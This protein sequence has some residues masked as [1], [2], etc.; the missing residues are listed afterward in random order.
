[1]QPGFI[2]NKSLT[3]KEKTVL[4]AVLKNKKDLKILLRHSWYRIPSSY[5]PKRKADYIAFYQ[6]S[7]FG[8]DGKCIRYFA[9]IKNISILKRKYLLPREQSHDRADKNYHKLTLCRIQKLKKPITNKNRMRVSFGF[10]TLKK[11][12]KAREVIDLFDIPP[13]ES[14]LSK[15]LNKNEIAASRQHIIRLPNLKKHILDFAVFCKE[16][17]LNI[18]CDLEKW[19]LIRAQRIKDEKRDKAL[20]KLGW[21]ILRLKG[22]EI[23]ND[24]E[25]C[26]KNIK[27]K[28]KLLGGVTN[29]LS[30][31]RVLRSP[32]A[33]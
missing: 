30:T 22:Y 21:E 31:Y 25:G 20:K 2:K 24:I 16:G 15:A 5:I 29:H 17:A 3:L 11:L 27:N 10:T 18:E 6:P 23:V 4:V 13:I 28:I 1:M 7:I 12:K 14:I 33:K 8:G 26:I 19:H 32:W 9:R